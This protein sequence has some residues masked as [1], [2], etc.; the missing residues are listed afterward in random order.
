MNLERTLGIVEDGKVAQDRGSHI[1]PVTRPAG[2]TPFLHRTGERC[3]TDCR[4]EGFLNDHFED[5]NLELPLRLPSES[6]VLPR[7]GIAR[8]LSIPE[9]ADSYSNPYLTSFRVLNGILHNPRSDRRTTQGTFHVAEGGLPIP[10]DKRAVPRLGLRRAVP[11]RRDPSSD[12]LV[13]PY[14]ANRPRSLRTFV[15]LLL[16]PIVCPEVPGICTRRRW[17]FTSSRQAD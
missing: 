10:G 11:P 4:I 2:D 3:P 5:L 1:R 14:T 7:H 15:S 16:R 6:L 8:D 17:R 9:G 12:L 13:V